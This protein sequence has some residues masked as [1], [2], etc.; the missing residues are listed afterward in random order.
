[1]LSAYFQQDEHAMKASE[2]GGQVPLPFACSFSKQSG[3]EDL[4]AVANEDGKVGFQMGFCLRKLCGFFFFFF[5][6]RRLT[7]SGDIPHAGMNLG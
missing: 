2:E 4:V 7:R 5:F 3:N 6:L 1:M